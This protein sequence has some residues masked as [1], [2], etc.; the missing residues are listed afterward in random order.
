V[1][2]QTAAT[3]EALVLQLT[4]QAASALREVRAQ[5]QVPEHFGVRV[6]G[7][8]TNTKSALHLDF[9]EEPIAGDEISE[10]KGM[11]LFV[12]PNMAEPLAHLAIDVKEQSSASGLELKLRAQGDAND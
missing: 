5:Q 11:K 12:A 3:R 10:G 8:A 6:S 2:S 4:E 1:D 7:S 9:V